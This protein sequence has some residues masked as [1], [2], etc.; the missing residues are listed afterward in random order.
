MKP[1]YVASRTHHAEIWQDFREGG[2]NIVSSWI[3]EAG[4]GQ[5]EDLGELWERICGELDKAAVFVLYAELDDFPLKG[6]FI[7]AGYAMA[8]KIP[9]IVCAPRCLFP[10][11][12]FRPI[13]SW[14]NHPMVQ[15]IDDIVF[16]MRKAE[17][18][19]KE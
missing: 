7:E 12:G 10:A 16:A 14:I 11:P 5:T 13:G 19:A 6:A 1:I 17:E 18:L 15:R 9:I 3:D 8:R 2:T 4:P